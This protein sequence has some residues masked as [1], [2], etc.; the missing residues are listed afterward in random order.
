MMMDNRI[1]GICPSRWT[2]AHTTRFLTTKKY[3]PISR[4]FVVYYAANN[5]VNTCSTTNPKT[6][7]NISDGSAMSCRS[8]LN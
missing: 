4:D 1:P 7:R 5:M 6:V 2:I 3:S 8:P